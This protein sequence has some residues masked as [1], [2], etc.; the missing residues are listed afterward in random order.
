M[1]SGYELFSHSALE[2]VLARGIRS[3]GHFFQT[4]IKAYC[5]N[6]PVAEVPIHYRAASDS[7]NGNVIRDAFENCG[8]CSA[9]GCPNKL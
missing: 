2:S 5:R 8:G 4:E 3:R 6:L 7:V 9:C 1:T